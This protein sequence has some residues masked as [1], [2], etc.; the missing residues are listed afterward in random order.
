MPDGGGTTVSGT[1]HVIG[2]IGDPVSHS[3]SPRLHNAAFAA[4]GL[5]YVYVPLPVRAADVGAAVKGLAALGLR[6]ANVT[7]PHKGAVVPFLDELSD[8]ARLLE[9]VNTIVVEG[10]R[11][12]GHNTDVEG[13]RG[14]LAAAA[15]DSLRGEPALVLGGGGAARAAALALSRL[16][17]SAHRRQSDARQ[18]GAPGGAHH[19]GRPRRALRVASVVRPDGAGRDPAA[20]R[21]QRD[22]AGHDGRG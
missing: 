2:I 6:G 16:G 5:D 19:G 8:D 12:H 18:G 9:A 21:R 4:L 1:T 20:G 13:V 17:L 11:L 7:I 22:L 15:G 14:A 10:R 3:L